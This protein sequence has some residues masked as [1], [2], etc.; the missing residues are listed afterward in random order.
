MLP[1][2]GDPLL[3]SLFLFFLRRK[4]AKYIQ[5]GVFP[6]VWAFGT[7]CR[8]ALRVEILNLNALQYYRNY[9]LPYLEWRKQKQIQEAY[10]GCYI[11]VIA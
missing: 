3:Q 10:H 11:L 8:Y 2:G 9:S 5:G 1:A 7:V 4:Q 6:Y